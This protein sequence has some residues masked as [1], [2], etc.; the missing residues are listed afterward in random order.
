MCRAG[1]NHWFGERVG[2]GFAPKRRRCS[3]REAHRHRPS[4]DADEVTNQP[5]GMGTFLGALP[6]KIGLNQ[7]FTDMSD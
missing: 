7:F 4:N 1:A 2:R 3:V 5:T 6:L